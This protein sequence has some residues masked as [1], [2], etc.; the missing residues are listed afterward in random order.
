MYVL[1][2][3]RHKCIALQSFSPGDKLYYTQSWCQLA[4]LV[5]VSRV[6]KIAEY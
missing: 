5:A 2:D 3:P 6:L 1:T 4:P